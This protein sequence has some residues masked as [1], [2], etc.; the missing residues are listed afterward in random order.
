[1]HA[2]TATANVNSL[3]VIAAVRKTIASE[4]P[5][6]QSPPIINLI[7]QRLHSRRPFYGLEVIPQTRH[8]SDVLDLNTFNEW[9]PLFIS[10]G[11]IGERVQCVAEMRRSSPALRLAH[12]LKEADV[13]V[14][15]HLSCAQLSADTARQL[16]SENV[17][18][19]RGG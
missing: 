16:I 17:L 11:W 2:A 9:P 12:S 14:L 8:P 15:S 5:K 4:L 7:R 10:V 6:Q 18:A 13:P 19:L 3:T 1:M